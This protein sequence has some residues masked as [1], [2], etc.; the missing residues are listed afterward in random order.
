MVGRI[1]ERFVRYVFLV[2]FMS[3]ASVFSDARDSR[4]TRSGIG[5]QYWIA[6]EYCYD[7]NRPMTERRWKDNI[8]W[9]AAT[10]RDYGYDMISND[11]WIE[12][13]QTVNE[14]G[15]IT[16]YNSGWKH[17]FGYW[18]NYIREKGM[19]MG[20]YYNP[21]WMTRTAYRKNCTVS[22]TEYTAQEIAGEHSF[23]S[24]L[25]WVDVDRPGAEEWVKGYVRHFKDLGA[26]FLR[27]DFLENYENHYGSRRY[28]KALQWIAEEAGDDLFISLVMPN[29]HE[30]ARTELVYG[31]MMRISDDCFGGEWDFV[32]SRR[33]GQ[34]KD[35]WPKYANVFD[36]MVAFSD[37]AGR[38]QM[39]MDGD[40]MRLNR[41]ASRQEREFLFS[42]MVMGGSALAIA[43]QYDTIT[44][45]AEEVYKNRELLELH[46]QGFL[47]KP[48]SGDI[49]NENSSK[50]IGQLPDGDFVVGFFNREDAARTYGIDFFKD[51]GIDSGKVSNIRDMWKHTDFG[52]VEGCYSVS[53]Q[54]HSCVIVR[55][56]PEGTL[57]FQAEAASMKNGV[58]LAYD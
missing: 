35:R 37:V 36:G 25:H 3:F 8:D 45:D 40:F 23:N 22:G 21:L 49:R 14:N 15:Y 16:K 24:E 56:T 31:D 32:S 55:I 58:K 1:M 43:D 18:S 11:G 4:F 26:V 50:W 19:K 51:L 52:P 57:R 33:R 48:M 53:L 41:L 42:L 5:P 10:F 29:C 34:V 30:H 17:D 2:G 39:I 13:A 38:G 20:V 54:P 47:A 9:M 6:Y 7:L 12:A 27:I 44:A 46:S 28:A